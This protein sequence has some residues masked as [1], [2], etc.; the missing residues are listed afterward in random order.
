MWY[1]PISVPICAKPTC[2]SVLSDGATEPT[3]WY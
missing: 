1:S 2:N 3:V